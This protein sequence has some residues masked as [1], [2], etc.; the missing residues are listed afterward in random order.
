MLVRGLFP[1]HDAAGK[2][3][4]AVFVVRDIT[5]FYLAMRHTRNM[6]VILT[7]AAL[8]VGMLLVLTLLNRLVF[9]RLQHIIDVATHV[10]GGDYQTEIRVNSQDE[11]GEFE[12]LFEQFRRVFVDLLDHVPELQKGV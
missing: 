3:V 1:I 8:T 11:V 6:L 12:Q 10:V 5:G 9:L 2:T 7:C 4:G